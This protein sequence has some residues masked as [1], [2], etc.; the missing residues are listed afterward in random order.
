[1]KKCS[2]MQCHGMVPVKVVLPY[3]VIAF[4]CFRP[5]ARPMGGDGGR[6]AQNGMSADHRAQIDDLQAQVA[7][8][9]FILPC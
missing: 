1:M 3:V 9:H 6:G 7:Q 4:V 5:A 2:G 8:L